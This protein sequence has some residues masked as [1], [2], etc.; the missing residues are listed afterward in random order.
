[1]AR[2]IKENFNQDGIDR[3]GFLECMAWAGTGLIWTVSGGV[4]SSKAFGQM[5]HYPMGEGAGFTFVQIS[6]SHIGF[7][8]EANK[9]VTVTLQ[10]AINKINALEHTP[11]F[12]IHTG[13]LSHLSKPTEFDTLDQVLRSA[14]SGQTFFVPG[15][16][17][18]LADNG[19]QYLERYGKGTKGAGWYSFDHKGVHFIGLVNVVDLKARRS[20]NTRRGTTGV[21]RKGSRRALQQHAN[22]RLCPHPVVDRVSGL[23]LGHRRWC[24][25][26]VIPEAVRL[27][28]GVERTHSSD[29]AK[30][31]RQRV[32]SH[33]HVYGISPAQARNRDV[34][35]PDESP[36]RAAPRGTGDHARQLYSR[37]S[38]ARG[39][40]FHSGHDFRLT[41]QPGQSGGHDRREDRQFLVCSPVADRESRSGGDLDQSGRHSAQCREHGE[42]VLLARSRYRPDILIPLWGAGFLPV[43]LQDSSHHDGNDSGRE[44][45]LGNGVRKGAN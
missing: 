41:R 32:L 27:G 22:R 10:E 38:H 21:A 30:G 3:R 37:S 31:R 33:G 6:D 45:R 4:L 40:R 42:E 5:P 43:L 44:K 8:K 13:D 2:R 17:D 24:A 7:N 1:M 9:D 14:K 19:Q 12:L 34:T 29:H 18:M 26:F 36:G 20:R 25:G 35:G 28:H 16:H 11:D 23:G 39:G 15:E